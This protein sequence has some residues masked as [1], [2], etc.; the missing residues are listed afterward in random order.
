VEQ[1]PGSAADEIRVPADAGDP[2]GIV[3]PGEGA[4]DAP[5]PAAMPTAASP[6][7]ASTTGAGEP[8]S[9][10]QST[11]AR[12]DAAIPAPAAQAA[13]PEPA[14]APSGDG[15]PQVVAAAATVAAEPSATQPPAAPRTSTRRRFVQYLLGF[16]VVTTLALVAAPVVA[17]LIPPKESAAGTGGKTLAGTTADI[18]PGKGKVVAMGS[19]PTIVVNTEQGVK[20]YSA[21]CTHLGCI[22]AFDDQSGSISCPCHG[23]RFSPLTGTVQSGPPPAPLAPVTVSVEGDQIFLVSA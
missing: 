21:I 1:G 7:A 15:A 10:A 4:P 18:P 23:G 20:A 8:E 5:A 11:A 17:F 22:V 12:T 19:K 16:S 14:V 13:L 2:G 3:G 9:A 6:E